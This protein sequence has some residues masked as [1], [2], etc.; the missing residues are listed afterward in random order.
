MF[1]CFNQDVSV[2]YI[3]ST[4][5]SQAVIS[6][7]VP[8]LIDN[9]RLVVETDRLDQSKVVED[10][11]IDTTMSNKQLSGTTTAAV[12]TTI[13]EVQ[14]PSSSTTTTTTTNTAI[15][16]TTSKNHNGIHHQVSQQI[17]AKSTEGTT[18]DPGNL[19]MTTSNASNDVVVVNISDDEEHCSDNDHSPAKKRRTDGFHAS[20]DVDFSLDKNS[21]KS[22]I[23]DALPSCSKFDNGTSISVEAQ[24]SVDNLAEED[25]EFQD[26]I[27]TFQEVYAE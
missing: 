21:E 14:L 20:D 25:E 26:I 12:M 9:S 5:S 8:K 23:G 27:S 19:E 3:T 18:S 6:G 22:A 24:N 10:E 11:Y 16:T 17:P 7:T 4:K 1:L 2:N 13:P 15:T